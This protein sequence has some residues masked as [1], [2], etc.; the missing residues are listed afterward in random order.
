MTER[1]YL[2]QGDPQW[3]RVKAG[4]SS[5]RTM[6]QVGCVLTSIAQALRYLEVDPAATPVSVQQA[7]LQAW[8]GHPLTAPF[9]ARTAAA[10]MPRIGRAVG[11]DIGDRINHIEGPRFFGALAEAFAGV[12]CALLHVDSREDGLD[13]PNH[14]VLGLR[15]EGSMTDGQLVYADPDGGYEGRLPM[16]TLR[17]PSPKD[18]PYQLHGLR[19]VFRARC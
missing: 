8:D 11:V 19:T 1:P 7:A 16:A 10:F 9:A 4:F 3:A 17:A 6:S 2:N 15:I 14:W 18:K 5:A 12:G 13:E